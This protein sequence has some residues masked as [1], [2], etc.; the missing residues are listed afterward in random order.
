MSK[1]EH[2]VSSK[3]PHISA[4]IARLRISNNID[5]DFMETFLNIKCLH[6]NVTEMTPRFNAQFGR[7]CVSYAD[8]LMQLG[9]VSKST[10]ILES[11]KPLNVSNPSTLEK[12]ALSHIN[13]SLSK[14]KKIRGHFKE[15]ADVEVLVHSSVLKRMHT[16]TISDAY[17]EMGKADESK[18]ILDENREYF[19]SVGNAAFSV[20]LAES[21]VWMNQFEEAERLYLEVK[22]YSTSNGYR[23][24][25]LQSCMGLAKISHLKSQWDSAQILWEETS[26]LISEYRWGDSL[27]AV[28][29]LSMFD[30]FVRQGEMV[31]SAPHW[32]RYLEIYNPED[33]RFWVTGLGR[34]VSHLREKIRAKGVNP[35]QSQLGI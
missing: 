5:D 13:L 10:K 4:W 16:Y 17:L 7:V 2:L 27:S 24:G 26:N 28:V 6:S 35:D 20:R 14:I 33:F 1:V 11:W 21:L 8:R 19:T 9:Q 12:I 15:S 34:W 29:H 25:V 32:K 22:E 23:M 3:R 31:K 18:K 30:L